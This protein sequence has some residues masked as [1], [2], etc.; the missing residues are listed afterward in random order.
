MPEKPGNG[1]YGNEAYDPETGQYV[2]SGG[3]SKKSSK[4][5]SK[6]FANLDLLLDDDED[7]EDFGAWIQRRK[8]W[9]SEQPRDPDWVI[10]NIEQFF[11]KEVIDYMERWDYHTSASLSISGKTTYDANRNMTLT[12]AIALQMYQPMT[13][14]EPAE[15]D[16]MKA[17]IARRGELWPS[18]AKRV[19]QLY[20]ERGFSGDP[21]VIEASYLREQPNDLILTQGAYGSCVY[22]AYNPHTASSYARRSSV[23]SSRNGSSGY[24]MRYILDQSSTKGINYNEA[25][26]LRNRMRGRAQ[27]AAGRITQHA[28]KMGIEQSKAEKLGRIFAS[29][30]DYDEMFP[31]VICGYDIVYD[32]GS[33]Y[34][35]LLRFRHVKTRRDWE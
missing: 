33:Q 20:L 7:G 26:Q 32:P 19:P 8:F 1:G 30:I 16:A 11:D 6:K 23:G 24:I 25:M 15:F 21:R 12:N 18:D 31:A 2:A 3:G 5:I 9:L 17:E 13:P 35:L 22:T 14:I 28:L 4:K 27:E 29:T 10:D 34:G